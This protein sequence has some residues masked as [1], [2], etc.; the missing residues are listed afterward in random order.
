MTRSVRDAAILLSGMAGHD[1]KD[2]TSAPM[3]VPD[4]EAAVS[5][6]VRGLKVGIPQ[7]YR[8][9]GM[10]AEIDD[11]WRQ[12]E[13]WL[14]EAGAE[15]AT[16]RCRTPATRSPPTTSLRRPRRRPTSPVTTVFAS[17]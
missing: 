1:P 9:D 5:L 10:A 14:R 7:E 4:F 8:I 13:A 3:A 12:G 2:S 16:S 17:G 11:L 15:S 6:G